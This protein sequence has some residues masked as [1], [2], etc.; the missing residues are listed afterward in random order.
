MASS[1]SLDPELDLNH[2]H[3][4]SGRDDERVVAGIEEPGGDLK[5][6]CLFRLNGSH[7][8]GDVADLVALRVDDRA[9]VRRRLSGRN[10]KFKD[11]WPAS[12]ER[13]ARRAVV[14]HAL[15]RNDVGL[16]RLCKLDALIGDR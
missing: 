14:A 3:P 6:D 16:A 2:W 8:V 13:F 12:F 1:L 11:E 7:N 10:Q 4:T 15:D 5:G 9:F